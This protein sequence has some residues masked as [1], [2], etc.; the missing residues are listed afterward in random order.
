MRL[1]PLLLAVALLAA[2]GCTESD[3]SIRVDRGPGR[4]VPPGGAP[5]GDADEVVAIALEDLEAYWA[6][7][8]PDLYDTDFEPLRG[9][10]L[11]FGPD[12]PLPR[13]GDEQLRY[14]QVAENALYCPSADLVAWDRSTLIPDLQQRFGPLTVGMVMAHEFAHA[15]QNRADTE[16][17]TVTL[18]LQA[19]CFAGAWVA[20]VDDRISTFASDGDALDQ[21]VAGLLE[22]R[23]TVGVPGFDPA[24]HGSG[25]DRVGAFQD[26]FERGLDACAA[27]EEDPPEVVAIPF[28]GLDDQVTG[29]NLPLADL[30]DPLVLDLDAFFG[31]FVRDGGSRWAPVA[32]VVLFDPAD[33]PILCGDAEI[34]GDELVDA[35][36]HCVSDRT[37]YLDGVDLVPSLDEIG[38]FAVAGEIARLHAFAAQERLGID[39][40]DQQL[41]LHADCLAGAFSGAEFDGDVPEVRDRTADPVELERR[42][43]EGG[44]RPQQLRLS[45][46]D[47]DE[48]VI[49][50][51]AFGGEDAA[52][53]F[54]RTAAFRTGFVDG[55]GA[56]EAFLG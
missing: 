29:G 20:D 7:A 47:L 41:E 17:A 6:D 38:D 28:G 22:L 44:L 16:A 53:A 52:S 55:A 13:C 43:I 8:M 9:G 26:G 4:A 33:G 10:Y 50:F 11:P 37:H 56:C 3:L 15:V 48:V 30:L 34:A 40:D 51:L 46:G 54:E 23:D 18:E 24:A 25:F 27:Y 1:R 35:S 36:F 42:R 2:G 45:P 32:E 14:E 31:T 21:A 19:D 49:A 5:P 12:T 39:G